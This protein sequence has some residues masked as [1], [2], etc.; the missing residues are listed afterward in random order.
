[1]WGKERDYAFRNICITDYYIYIA[2]RACSIRA[3]RCPCGHIAR[4]RIK[5]VS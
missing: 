3:A 5:L 1:V 4:R 2:Y